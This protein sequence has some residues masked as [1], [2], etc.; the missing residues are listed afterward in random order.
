MRE[1]VFMSIIVDYEDYKMGT[2]K[3]PQFL[4]FEEFCEANNEN[5]SGFETEKE[6]KKFLNKINDLLYQFVRY[7]KV[8]TD[9]CIE[10]A[11]QISDITKLL[12]LDDA[13]N[14]MQK[15]IEAWAINEY[16]KM[17][18]YYMLKM[19]VAFED[20]MEKGKITAYDVDV[21]GYIDEY[22][23]I[24]GFQDYAIKS[25]NEAK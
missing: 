7:F 6:Q 14:E 20:L 17:N 4:T 24:K 15:V 12:L 3:K 21:D 9:D 13:D 2:Y 23:F 10:Y 11:E 16:S 5:P 19:K 1:V 18:A 8:D 22:S 25:M